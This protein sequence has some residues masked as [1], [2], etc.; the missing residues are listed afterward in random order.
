MSETWYE[1]ETGPMVRPYTVT[2]GR[3]RPAAAHSLDLMSRVAAV[4]A[5]DLPPGVEP[6]LDHARSSLLTLLRGGPHTVAE[7]AA[8]ADLPL[9]VVRVLLADLV[10]A[11]LVTAAPPAAGEAARHDPELLREIAD[12]LRQ[13]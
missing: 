1:D 8:D 9:T 2:R 5:E 13:L 6:R 3:T 7:V 10:E 12:R 11:G 4:P